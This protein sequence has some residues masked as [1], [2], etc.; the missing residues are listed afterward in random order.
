MLPFRNPGSNCS[1][2]IESA[3]S[4]AVPRYQ[5]DKKARG[6]CFFTS[7]SIWLWPTRAKVGPECGCQSFSSLSLGSL[8][9]GHCPYGVPSIPDRLVAV[10]CQGP[11]PSALPQRRLIFTTKPNW[12]K[13]PRPYLK[14][15]RKWMLPFRNP[16]SSCDLRDGKGFISEALLA[17]HP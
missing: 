16:G 6:S 10:L 5:L 15:L 14:N 3:H 9:H 12:S 11:G 8:P 1:G 2:W 4:K 17:V 7:V 13:N